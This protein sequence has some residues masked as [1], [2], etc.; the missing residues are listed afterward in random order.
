MTRKI[1]LSE[2][3]ID[4]NALPLLPREHAAALMAFPFRL[5][6]TRLHVAIAGDWDMDRLQTLTDIAGMPVAPYSAGED[7]IL[8]HIDKLLGQEYA[9]TIA[10]RFFESERETESGAK[11]NESGAREHEDV[12]QAPVVRLVDSILDAAVFNNA[13]DIHVEPYG[14]QMRARLR[15]DGFLVTKF[16]VEL[17][18]LPNVMS[19]LK[20]MAGLDIAEKRSPQDGQF[21]YGRGG[22]RLDFRLSTLPTAFGEKAVIR[23]LYSGNARMDMGGLGFL[24]EDMPPLGR[25]F[26]SSYGAVFM[27]GPT[28]SGKSTTLAARLGKLN[29]EWRNIVTVEDPVEYPIHGVNHVNVTGKLGFPGALRHI[30]RQDPDVILIGEVRDDETAKIAVQA[31]ITG[32][33]VLSTIHTNDAAGVV[34]RLVNL[35]VE[36]Y[37]VAAALKG[38][39]SQRLARKLCIC[40]R[41]A[42]L[43]PHEAELLCLAAGM[44]VSAPTGCERCGMT[45]YLS[46]F[47]IYEYFVMDEDARASLVASPEKFA[48]GIRAQ[49]RLLK[50]A[51]K[52]VE[53]GCTSPEEAL[54]VS[55]QGIAT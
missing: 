24:E 37:M 15:I 9:E 12:A 50:N 45:G 48:R 19:R 11:A 35:G 7:D 1:K 36:P 26:D 4:A 18:L 23:L 2:T 43:L 10:S 44:E 20:I 5:D 25:L 51:A 16:A 52:R 6:D 31:S 29:V 22:D 47:A 27:T 3:E 54:R 55:W 39:V 41:P 33:L 38:A 40:K 30:L 34:E 46:R 32:H 28:G 42:A 13:S 14:A 21:S 17:A 53:S 49:R 8:R